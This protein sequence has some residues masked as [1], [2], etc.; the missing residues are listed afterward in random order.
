MQADASVPAGK[1]V[2]P[3]RTRQAVNG[4]KPVIKNLFGGETGRGDIGCTVH[5][6]Q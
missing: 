1:C 6:T 2:Y 5:M 3:S 4:L